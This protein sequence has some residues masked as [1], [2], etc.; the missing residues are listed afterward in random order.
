MRTTLPLVICYAYLLL[1]AVAA[2]AQLLIPYL[3]ADGRYGLADEQ[4]T[5]VV[6]ADL[7]RVPPMLPN[8]LAVNARRQGQQVRVFR[9]GTVVPN[10]DGTGLVQHVVNYGA[11]DRVLD[12]LRHLVAAVSVQE[13]KVMDLYRPS[14]LPAVTSVNTDRIV[15]P[16]FGLPIFMWTNRVPGFH[17][18]MGAARIHKALD[19]VNFVDTQLRELLPTDYAAG[20]V[21]DSA[22]F[23]IAEGE[24]RVGVADRRGNV[25]VPCHWPHL[26]PAGRTGY[27]VARAHGSRH[28]S[29]PH[30]VGLIDAD[31]RMVI[32]TAYYA[33]T[34]VPGGQMLIV[35]THEYWGLMDYAGRTILAAT[36]SRSITAL[37]NGWALVNFGGRCNFINHRGERA[38]PQD[39]NSIHDAS[40]TAFPHYIVR[41]NRNTWV[42][43]GSLLPLFHDSLVVINDVYTHPLRVWVRQTDGTHLLKNAEHTVLA[44][45]TFDQILPAVHTP[46]GYLLIQKDTLQGVIGPYGEKILPTR[47]STITFQPFKGDTLLWARL[48]GSDLYAAHDQRGQRVADIPESDIPL[49]GKAVTRPFSPAELAAILPAGFVKPERIAGEPTQRAWDATGLIVV[50]QLLDVP[51]APRDSPNQPTAPVDA[52]RTP[53]TGAPCGIIDHRGHWV[54]P[55]KAGII[56][57]PVT[58]HL[59]A[60]LPASAGNVA[61]QFHEHGIVLHRIHAALRDTLR[62]HWLSF[63][64]LP[65]EADNL[66]V[67]RIRSGTRQQAE[68]AYFDAAGQQLTPFAY[69][70]GPNYLL[71]HNVVDVWQPDGST[72][73]SIVDRHGRVLH[74]LGT[75]RTDH[76]PH[77]RS[78]PWSVGV[79]VVQ[80][81]TAPDRTQMGLMDTVGRLLLPT[82]YRDLEILAGDSFFTATAPQ[83]GRLLLDKQNR[84]RFTFQGDAHVQTRLLPDGHWLVGN[85]MQTVHLSPAGDVLRVFD[86]ALSRDK[87][88]AELA[89][90]FAIFLIGERAVWG[91]LATGEL[92]WE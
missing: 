78:N 16:T 67:G 8:M 32:D 33:I 48:P 42:L 49:W 25:R 54:L 84:V 19:K 26:Q 53:A 76:P 41:G 90:R 30:S 15:P 31:G 40:A 60:E 10:P 73:Q 88:A 38:L 72:R 14:S 71:S 21:A 50:Q 85:D 52:H 24:G 75:L 47:F 82:T 86:Y 5:L 20:L 51:V 12:T 58:Q 34:P 39:A 27:F 55:P 79:F 4:R 56:Y 1:G 22:F 3:G 61:R 43:D 91:E 46:Q 37:P 45:G 62:V 57:W 36:E 28:P 92:W 87:P 74:D 70:D 6:G 13:V 80:V 83:G 77:K 44:A 2:H 7:E 63:S 18:R 35:R 64:T 9:N 66:R 65:A 23:I 11:D 29:Y 17:F 81:A 89:R 59:V 68:Y 69:A